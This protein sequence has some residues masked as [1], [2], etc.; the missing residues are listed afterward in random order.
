M[1]GKVARKEKHGSE[2]YKNKLWFISVTNACVEDRTMA[3]LGELGGALGLYTY[4]N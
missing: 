3:S 2:L 1:Q 4:I